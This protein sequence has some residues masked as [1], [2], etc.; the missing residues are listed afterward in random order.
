[1]LTER[2]ITRK[3]WCYKYSEECARHEQ[4]RTKLKTAPG[5]SYIHMTHI[6]VVTNN[7]NTGIS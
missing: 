5:T 2:T 7:G 3:N 6:D 1:M 4:K